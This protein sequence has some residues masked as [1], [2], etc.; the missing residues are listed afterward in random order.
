VDALIPHP[1][2]LGTGD[3]AAALSK[4]GSYATP[5]AFGIDV[6]VHIETVPD[7]GVEASGPAAP[8]DVPGG[9]TSTDEESEVTA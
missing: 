3:Q 8:S 9:A 6:P 1:P 5:N 4:D 2:S 7:D